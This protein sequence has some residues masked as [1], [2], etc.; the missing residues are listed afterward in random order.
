M[1]RVRLALALAWTAV[2]RTARWIDDRSWLVVAAFVVVGYLVIHHQSV[3]IAETQNL[4]AGQNKASAESRVKTVTQRCEF[5][6][7]VIDELVLRAPSLDAKP[8]HKSYDKCVL[9]LVKV[10]EEASAP[11]LPSAK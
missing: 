1:S 3:R 11:L 5:T 7:L 8:F 10:K 4:L 9:S 2:C 6:K